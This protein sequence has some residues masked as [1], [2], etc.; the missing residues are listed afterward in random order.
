MKINPVFMLICLAIAVLAGYGFFSWNSGEAYQILITI[1]AGIIIFVT[2]SG[3]I[4]IQSA[5]GR[6]SLGN[7]RALSIVFFLIEVI[8]NIIF[9]IITIHTPTAYIVI[10]GIIFLVYI[11]I[12]YVISR[13]LK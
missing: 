12:A 9:S 5:S 3:I 6:G 11:L 8:S 1:S 10:N 7:I 2:L 4:A 13:A